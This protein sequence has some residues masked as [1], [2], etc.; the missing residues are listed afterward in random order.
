MLPSISVH[1]SALVVLV[2]RSRWRR[3]Q[4]MSHLLTFLWI[5][6]RSI[7][8]I[9]IRLIDKGKLS[10]VWQFSQTFDL[11]E[12]FFFHF[13]CAKK[14]LRATCSAAVSEPHCMRCM[15]W[16]V[17]LGFLTQCVAL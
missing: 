14:R 7:T 17:S 3:S 12:A 4:K 8:L 1:F 13:V 5:V 16:L 15:I 10:A 11:A 2:A 6:L 9:L